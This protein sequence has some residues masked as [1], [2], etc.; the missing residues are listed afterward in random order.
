[1]NYNVM[2]SLVCPLTG[3]VFTGV[4][5]NKNL[6]LIIWYQG[7]RVVQAGDILSSSKEG[8]KINDKASDMTI[9]SV[10]PFN[11]A[12]WT[13]L[14]QRTACPANGIRPPSGC[15]RQDSCRF[16]CCPYG[17]EKRVAPKEPVSSLRG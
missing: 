12:N 14:T 16:I 15:H 4:I 1:M 6:K 11:R 2:D 8:L 9:I 5:T 3:T 10:F 7:D 17:L 13:L